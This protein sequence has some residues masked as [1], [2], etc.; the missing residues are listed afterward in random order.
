VNGLWTYLFVHTE[1]YGTREKV[2]A[3]I[4]SRPDIIVNWY[5]CLPNS[6]FIVSPYT[7]EQLSNH[8]HSFSATGWFVVLDTATDRNGWLPKTAWELMNNPRRV[9]S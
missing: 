8:L 9:G 1:Q 6:F 3:F 7:A 4:E 5:Y 2:K